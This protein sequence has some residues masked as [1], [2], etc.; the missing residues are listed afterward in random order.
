MHL[1][2]ILTQ[3]V[4]DGL[5]IVGTLMIGYKIRHG[6]GLRFFGAALRATILGTAGLYGLMGYDLALMVMDVKFWCQWKNNN[7]KKA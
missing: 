3:L 2:R 6:W 4:A 1:E 7:H 5:L